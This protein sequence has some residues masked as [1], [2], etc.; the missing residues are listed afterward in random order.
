L[1]VLERLAENI[2]ANVAGT[3]PCERDVSHGSG[4]EQQG[5]CEDKNG[6]GDVEAVATAV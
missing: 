3:F 6:R 4:G 2:Q 1:H 5:D